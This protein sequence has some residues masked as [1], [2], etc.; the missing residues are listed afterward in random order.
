MAEIF[1][2]KD[3]EGHSIFVEVSSKRSGVEKIGRAEN[4]VRHVSKLFEQTLS[5]VGS[6]GRAVLKAFQEL[7]H[8]SGIEL[9]FSLRFSAD[10]EA[11]VISGEGEAEFKLKLAWS[12]STTRHPETPTAK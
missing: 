2:L 1:E 7:N 4:G 8:P 10:I 11:F 3:A 6:A 9:E 12:N 5:H